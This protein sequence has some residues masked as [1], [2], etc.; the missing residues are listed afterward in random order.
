MDRKNIGNRP[1]LKSTLP[2][3]ALKRAASPLLSF[4]VGQIQNE[5][6]RY[7]L[8]LSAPQRRRPS[9]WSAPFEAQRACA[10]RLQPARPL[11]GGEP[12]S[13]PARLTAGASLAAI[14][15]DSSPAIK[16]IACGA[17][18]SARHDATGRTPRSI[19][20]QPGAQA[21]SHRRGPLARNVAVPCAVGYRLALR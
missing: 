12:W 6:C 13:S 3:Q 10:P 1:R 2:N 14:A 7:C 9:L 4:A 16:G 5:V 8:L 11:A 17:G 20:A 19:P 21:D 15:S 18:S